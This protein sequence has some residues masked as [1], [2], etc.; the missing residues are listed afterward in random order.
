M[1]RVL[2]VEDSESKYS[3]ILELVRDVCPKCEIAR[4]ATVI[5]AEAAVTEQK[6]DLVVLDI[7]MDIAPSRLGHRSRGQANIGGLGIAQKMFLLN[8]ESPTIIVTAFDSFSTATMG[9]SGEIVD[10]DEVRRRALQYLP[11]SLCACLQYNSPDWKELFRVTAQG[12]L[13]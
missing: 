2:I 7:S 9:G 1:R 10:F 11:D 8:C 3:A 4:A 13:S 12:A 5:E 6:W